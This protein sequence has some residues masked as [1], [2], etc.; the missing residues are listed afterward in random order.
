MH[1]FVNKNGINEIDE[2][3]SKQ[4]IQNMIHRLA[5]ADDEDEADDILDKLNNLY[6]T[7]VLLWGKSLLLYLFWFVVDYGNTVEIVGQSLTLVQI[8]FQ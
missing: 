5:Y 1:K 4:V 3:V 8:S 6:F 2:D 7:I